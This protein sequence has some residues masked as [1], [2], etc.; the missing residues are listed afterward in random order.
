MKYEYAF[1]LS[2]GLFIEMIA[3]LL[4]IFIFVCDFVKVLA[5]WYLISSFR[6]LCMLLYNMPFLLLLGTDHNIWRA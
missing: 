3:N 6:I 2:Y 5:V 4:V 1:F